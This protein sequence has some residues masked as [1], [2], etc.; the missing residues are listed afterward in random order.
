MQEEEHTNF[1]GDK[2]ETKVESCK[3]ECHSSIV[4]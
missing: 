2:I 3:W 4:S 1:E